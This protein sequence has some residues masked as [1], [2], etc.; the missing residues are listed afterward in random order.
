MFVLLFPPAY[1]RVK[2]HY[3]FI[4]PDGYIGWIQV[5]FSD[6]GAQLFSLR[7]DGGYEINVPESG[8]S[9]TS[10]ILVMDAKGKDDF[11]YRTLLP[12]GKS[13]FRL[14]PSQYVIQ[15]VL[16]GGFSVGDTGGKGQGYSW[17][18]FVGPPEVRDKVPFADWAKV[19]ATHEK[20]DKR[21]TR[22][23]FSGPYPAPG[24]IVSTTTPQ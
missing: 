8:I 16:D 20:S 13:K 17:F 21:G 2:P 7:K 22:I 6:P 14:V 5:V 24:R 18:L 11:Y 9:R 23:E 10:E 4:L 3:S 19:I 12:D 15:G 1:G